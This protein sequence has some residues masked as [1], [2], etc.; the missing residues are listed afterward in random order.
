LLRELVGLFSSDAPKLIARIRRAI[1][2]GNA[3]QAK[4]AA[5]A[6]KGSV[7]NFDSGRVLNAVRQV[8]TLAGAG[9][10][11]EASQALAIAKNP[12]R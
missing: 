11:D 4:H 8:E 1:A 9:N 10:L 6:L 2:R 3:N 5:H 7:G 12:H